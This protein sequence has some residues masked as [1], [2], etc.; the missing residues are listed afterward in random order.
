MTTPTLHEYR[1]NLTNN[2]LAVLAAIWEVE[3]ESAL[4]LTIH[5][6]TV[7]IYSETVDALPDRVSHRERDDERYSWIKV[8]DRVSLFEPDAWDQRYQGNK[9]HLLVLLR[10][11]M[12]A[13]KAEQDRLV[14]AASVI[15]VNGVPDS[16]QAAF[17]D[18]P[19][20]EDAR[21]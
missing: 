1:V 11:K 12:E 18:E 7:T 20:V 13:L 5:R 4:Q 10:E 9:A 3:D 19:S 2:L 15:L 17:G 14:D 21:E 6:P 16:I 8:T